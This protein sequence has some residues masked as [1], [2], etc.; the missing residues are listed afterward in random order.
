MSLN[1]DDLVYKLRID[2]SELDAGARDAGQSMAALNAPTINANRGIQALGQSSKLTRQEMLAL[3]Y[4]VSDTVASLGSG[5]SP[6]TILLQQGPQVRD[7]FG[8]IGNAVRAIGSLITPAVA[9]FGALALAAGSVATAFVQGVVQSDALEKAINRTGN[10]AG[11][12][13]GQVDQMVKDVAAAGNVSEGSSRKIL[14]GM[15]RTGQVGQESLQAAATAAAAMAKAYG[16]TEEE[17]VKSFQGMSKG[18]ATWAAEQNKSM[19]FLTLEQYKY[20]RALEDQGKAT[21]AQ[22]YLFERLRE[23]ASRVTSNLGTL[24][25][26]W[27]AIGETASK[28]WQ[29]ILGIGRESTVEDRLAK[30]QSAVAEAEKALRDPANNGPFNRQLARGSEE[31]LEAKRETV[32]LL[33]KQIAGQRTVA[34][35]QSKAAAATRAAIEEEEK[36]RKD[37]GAGVRAEKP[38]KPE[39]GAAITDPLQEQKQL[40]LRSEIAG[41]EETEKALRARDERAAKDAEKLAERTEQQRQQRLDQIIGASS[42]ARA[43]KIRDEMS[44][45][46]QQ[47]DAGNVAD[48]QDYVAAFDDLQEK[49]DAIERPAQ[50]AAAAMSTFADQASRNIQDA[51]GETLQQML[52]GNFT[53]I[54]RMWVSLL[55][56]MVAQAAAAKLNETLFG[57]TNSSGQ[58]SGGWVDLALTAIRAFMPQADMGTPAGLLGNP[59]SRGGGGYEGMIP[60]SVPDRMGASSFG[61]SAAPRMGDVYVSIDSRTDQAQIAELVTSSVRESQML[62][63]EQ[64]RLEGVR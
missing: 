50:K 3:N 15:V 23:A 30:A 54:G 20:I 13:A 32:R 12:T 57:Q 16:M 14:L 29:L 64:L 43:K 34:A 41:R 1:L 52:E 17:V 56:R 42:Q 33:Q 62:T 31:E 45:L 8:G 11:V 55:N 53:S 46:M 5:M 36:K 10:A 51:L 18:V 39:F 22:L 28:A 4:T 9:G 21:E 26:A 63:L 25:R 49:L 58:R 48:L 6:L 24:E 38:A 40:F 59:H 35:D 19:N 7:A 27:N 37:K 44:F 60:A 61:L 2:P 47:F